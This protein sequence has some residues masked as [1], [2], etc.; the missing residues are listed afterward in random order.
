MKAEEIINEYIDSQLKIEP[1]PFL[2]TQIMSKLE[3]MEQR[4]F[5]VLS[6]IQKVLVAASITAVVILGISLGTSYNKETSNSVSLNI[7]DYQIENLQIFSDALE[8]NEE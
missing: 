2:T 6:S 3:S 4:K 1:N 5:Y 7:N 8:N